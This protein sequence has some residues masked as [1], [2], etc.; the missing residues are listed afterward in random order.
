MFFMIGIQTKQKELEYNRLVICS[1]CGSYGRYNVIMTY[2]VLTLFF[3]PVLRWGR[4][5]YVK[6]SCCGTEYALNPETGKHIERGNDTEIR[7][8]DLTLLSGHAGRSEKTCR[9]CGYATD[10]DF[11]FCPKCGQRF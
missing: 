5:Y 4:Q 1:A 11:A 3:I 2:T 9:N 10:E 6:M 7:P 8:E